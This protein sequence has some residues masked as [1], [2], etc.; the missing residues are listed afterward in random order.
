MDTPSNKSGYFSFKPVFIAAAV[1]LLLRSPTGC[2]VVRIDAD[3]GFCVVLALKMGIAG[4]K[5]TCN[6]FPLASRAGGCSSCI[7]VDCAVALKSWLN[8][9]PAVDDGLTIVCSLCLEG[10]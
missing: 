3:G 5:L 2:C 10:A 8:L 7:R 1:N 4:Y 9:D 6:C